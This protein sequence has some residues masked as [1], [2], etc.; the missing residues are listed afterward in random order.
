M[1]IVNRFAELNE[2]IVAWRHDLH[3]HPEIIYE[4]HRTA[5]TVAEKLKSF[6]FDEVATG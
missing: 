4:V 6:G 1:P 2:D 3:R 5:A